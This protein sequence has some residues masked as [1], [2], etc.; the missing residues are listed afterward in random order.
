VVLIITAAGLL[1]GCVGF[2]APLVAVPFLAMLIGAKDAVIVISIPVCTANTVITLSQRPPPGLVRR[3]LPII[4]PL[5]PA[6]VI[7][8]FFL[9]Q[10]DARAISVVVAVVALCFCALAFAGVRIDP[11]LWAER[12][13]SALL[14]GG[15]GLVTGSTGIP[16]PL[17]ALYLT[18]LRLDPRSFT[19]GISLLLMI[20]TSFQLLSYA[21]LGLYEDV[22]LIASLAMVPPI[23]IGQAIGGRLQSRIDPLRFTRIVLLLVTLS[24]LNLLLRGLGLL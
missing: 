18:V 22:R 4:V 7:G 3:F 10:M 19:Y 16:G 23:L 21:K 1:K 2:G 6:T 11:P 14:G 12:I 8:A 24:G 15:A 5:I 9:A 13:V 17:F 20:A